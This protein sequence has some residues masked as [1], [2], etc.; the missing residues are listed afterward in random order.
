MHT[1]L[2]EKLFFNNWNNFSKDWP[3]SSVINILKSSYDP[4]A[5]NSGRPK[6]FKFLRIVASVFNRLTSKISLSY[7]SFL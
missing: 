7:K 3:K 4:K 1:V 2:S 5:F 6:P